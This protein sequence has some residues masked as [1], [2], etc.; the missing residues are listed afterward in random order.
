MCPACIGAMALLVAK[1]ASSAGVAAL[2]VN[3]VREKSDK[4]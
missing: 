3:K 2:V 1:A 4:S